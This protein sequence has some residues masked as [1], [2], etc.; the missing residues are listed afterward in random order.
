MLGSILTI[1]NYVEHW[2]IVPLCHA[3]PCFAMV[4]FIRSRRLVAVAMD[5]EGS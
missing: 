2:H 3:L 1:L 4:L 5:H